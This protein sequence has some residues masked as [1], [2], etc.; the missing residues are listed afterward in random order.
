MSDSTA[1]PQLKLE[2]FKLVMSP[3]VT[4]TRWP[5]TSYEKVEIYVRHCCGLYLMDIELNSLMSKGGLGI[6][7]N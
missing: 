6:T 4:N 5:G 2:D 1:N 3:P 7:P